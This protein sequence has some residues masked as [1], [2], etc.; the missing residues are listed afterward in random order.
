MLARHL[1]QHQPKRKL[2]LLDTDTRF[3]DLPFFREWNLYRPTPLDESFDLI[4]C[5]PPFFN[6]SLSQLFT[7][8]RLLAKF[9]YSH[10]IAIAYLGRR[11]SALLG[12][13]AR[14]NLAPTGFFPIYQTVQ[15]CAK[16]DI[17]FYANFEWNKLNA[18]TQ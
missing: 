8:I 14:F 7:A 9:D 5:D 2:R 6:V 11:E 17:Q 15:S 13:F 18:P 3:A 12:T 10:K 4:L 16:N 1:H